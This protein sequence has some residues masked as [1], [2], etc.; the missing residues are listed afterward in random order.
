M[1]QRDFGSTQA[2]VSE[3][4]FGGWSIG[5]P[6]W[7]SP[8]VRDSKAALT[9]ALDAGVTFFDTAEEYGHTRSEAVFGEVLGGREVVAAT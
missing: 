4:G 1:N 6:Q 9:A 3:I 8:D 2:K 5:E 7:G